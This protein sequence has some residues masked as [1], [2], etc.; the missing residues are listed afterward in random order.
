MLKK[1]T[2]ALIASLISVASAEAG[3][4]DLYYSD[5]RADNFS[6]VTR[7]G[8]QSAA[9]AGYR[10]VNDQACI[11][12]FACAAMGHLVKFQSKPLKG[13]PSLRCVAM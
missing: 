5:A 13:I 3:T 6:A 1:A 9:D 2:I 7:A 11:A 8:K 4:L 10:I 12:D